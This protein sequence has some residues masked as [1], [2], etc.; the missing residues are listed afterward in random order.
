MIKSMTGFGRCEVANEN[1]KITIEIKAVNHR[2]CDINVK[3]PRKLMS[4]ET[5]IRNML[6]K[7][8]SKTVSQLEE[9][10]FR[11]SQEHTGE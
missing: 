7:Y 4:F 9:L 8:G 11:V 10:A 3:L 2:Y 1:Q 6:K 5:R